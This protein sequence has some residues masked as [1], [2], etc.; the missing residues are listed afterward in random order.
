MPESAK[1]LIRS[2]SHSSRDS[3]RGREGDAS[4][5]SSE[6]EDRQ[7]SVKRSKSGKVAQQPDRKAHQAQPTNNTPKSL[8]PPLVLQHKRY[9]PALE[10]H[11]LTLRLKDKPVGKA[12]GQEFRIQTTNYKDYDKV[13]AALDERK[14]SYH[15]Y[16]THKPKS[17]RF[18]VRGLIKE[19]DLDDLKAEVGELGF[20]V[21]HVDRK[22]RRNG[23]IL[24]LV[25]LELAATPEVDKV[26]EVTVLLSQHI[27]VEDEHP[28]GAPICARCLRYNH[29][30]AYCSRPPRCAIC[31]KDHQS[32]DCPTP[33]TTPTRVNCGASGKSG[34]RAT[35]KG[36]KRYKLY[37]GQIEPATTSSSSSES[38]SSA[39]DTE[40]ESVHRPK[41]RPAPLPQRSAWDRPRPPQ[42]SHQPPADRTQQKPPTSSQSL[43]TPSPATVSSDFTSFI[44]LLKQLAAVFKTFKQQ[45]L[46]AALEMFSQLAEQW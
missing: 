36:C 38:E 3:K 24:P 8:P 1:Q 19:T 46:M 31:T 29:T 6:E 33:K 44:N 34:H 5:S 7:K 25:L 12:Y 17:K 26:K 10:R 35:Y 20:K 14:L 32:K 28:K 4:G 30:Q 9:F 18:A 16:R 40:E 22:K 13:K 45:G 11:L 41:F 43:N 21:L 23:D 37:T 27:T 42:R 15:T 2:L 39:S